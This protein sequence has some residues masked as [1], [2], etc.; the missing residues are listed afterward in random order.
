MADLWSF[1][2]GT[3]V[4]A[5]AASLCN[6]LE[7][8]WIGVAAGVAVAVLGGMAAALMRRFGVADLSQVAPALMG[9]VIGSAIVLARGRPST[10]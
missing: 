4:G 5:M 10:G 9:V 2:V 3:I 6:R 7:N 8:R 1:M